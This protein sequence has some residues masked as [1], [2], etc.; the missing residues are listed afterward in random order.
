MNRFERDELAELI[1][2]ALAASREEVA[3]LYAV[4]LDMGGMVGAADI[5][6][7]AIREVW[8]ALFRLDLQE[9]HDVAQRIVKISEHGDR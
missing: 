4:P 3:S 5:A 6:R 7:E 9:S 2:K 1:S 8:Q